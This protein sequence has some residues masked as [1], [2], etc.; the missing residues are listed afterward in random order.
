MTVLRT[1]QGQTVRTAGI[2]QTTAAK[3]A[4]RIQAKMLART[5]VRMPMILRTAR[6]SLKRAHQAV[7]VWGRLDSYIT[8]RHQPRHEGVP[9]QPD[10]SLH[11]CLMSHFT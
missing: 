9:G 5:R 2:L 10:G 3:T 7:T 6:S 1:A 8:Q 4:R 11:A